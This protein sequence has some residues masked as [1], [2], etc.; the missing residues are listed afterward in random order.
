MVG[1]LKYSL[2]EIRTLHGLGNLLQ[3]ILNSI[4]ASEHEICVFLAAFCIN[5]LSETELSVNQAVESG[6]EK[7]KTSTV[8]QELGKG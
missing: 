6:I 4:P 3:I 7:A 8:L 2:I 1:S 5:W